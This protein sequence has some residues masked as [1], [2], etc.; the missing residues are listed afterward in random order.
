[1]NEYAAIPESFVTRHPRAHKHQQSRLRVECPH[2]GS[3]G[4]SRSSQ[5]LTP[6]YTETRF[7]CVNDA[8][9]HVWVAGMEVL[10]T[11][12]PAAAP[13]P[14]IDIPTRF[15]EPASPAI[16]KPRDLAAG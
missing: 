9:G 7:E 11:L 3:F 4:R 15:D 5:R 14:G 16:D 1:M 12:I 2:C 6:T 8:C 10:R 13:R